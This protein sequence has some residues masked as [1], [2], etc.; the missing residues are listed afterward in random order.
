MAITQYGAKA[1]SLIKKYRYAAL[2]LLVGLV[3]MWMPGRKENDVSQVTVTDA[4]P[5]TNI[6]AELT[7]I[8][9]QIEGV[10]T[11]K[12]M[13]TIEAWEYTIYQSDETR[14]GETI[15]TETVIITD[16]DR[17]EH[18]L[19]SQIRPVTYRGAIVVCQ[20]ADSPAT[21]LAIVEAVSRVTGLGADCISVLK[22]K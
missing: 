12:V 14:N 19:I 22:M 18:P 7:D 2:I 4:S 17:N 3:L 21:K 11:V 8:L 20:G 15:R 1:L 16:S 5:E 10:G 9:T 13:L 6:T